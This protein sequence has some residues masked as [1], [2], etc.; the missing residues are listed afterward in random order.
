M[1]QVPINIYQ[2]PRT[3]TIPSINMQNM[4][5]SGSLH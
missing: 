2:V 3:F 4:L 5:A 1:W